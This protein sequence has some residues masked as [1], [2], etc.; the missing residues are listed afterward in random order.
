ML[1]RLEQPQSDNK[2][3][4]V[5]KQPP[6]ITTKSPVKSSS[7][8]RL[9]HPP[10][11]A[12]VLHDTRNRYIMSFLDLPNE[13]I[14]QIA[15]D[16]DPPDTNAL[17]R[18][19][20]RLARL[21]THVLIDKLFLNNTRLQRHGQSVLLFAAGR[22]DNVIVK[23][24]L[25]SGLFDGG[26]ILIAA[27]PSVN[28]TTIQTLI[29]CGIDT[30]AK[31]GWRPTPL[32]AAVLENRPTIVK[33]LLGVDGI[34]VNSQRNGR[35]PLCDAIRKGNEETVRLLLRDKRT[36]LNQ[37]HAVSSALYLAVNLA[38]KK[39]TQLLLAE[40]RLDVNI[41]GPSGKTPLH[42]AVCRDTD[43]NHILSTLLVDKRID[44][45]PKCQSGLTPF[46]E[47]VKFGCEATVRIFLT[48]SAVDIN[49]GDPAGET[50]IHRAISLG[51]REVLPLLVKDSRLKING[52]DRHGRT[53]LHLAASLD[54]I[55]TVRLLLDHGEVNVNALSGSGDTPLHVAANKGHERVVRLLLGRDDL[56]IDACRPGKSSVKSLARNYSP[57]I[58]KLVLD[59]GSSKQQGVQETAAF[60]R[61]P[62]GGR[63]GRSRNR[64][65]YT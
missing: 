23:R 30:T 1:L 41:R 40:E 60:G 17:L 63:T 34:V 55:H 21:L 49:A 50:P 24:I 64:W 9:S 36:Q 20:R 15:R 25:D 61:E 26:E 52:P 7:N 46:Y 42:Q 14:L 37:P 19:N 57:A 54:Q 28:E 18:T 65:G 48:S 43:R 6:Y 58:R 12:T 27:V 13:V 39:M 8:L 4:S 47:A 45:N 62:A 29:D 11:P 16:Q 22:Q 59:Y 35:T 10:P 32:H 33:L 31:G 5:T 53:P 38:D 56:D 2:S 3:K 51:W 44:T